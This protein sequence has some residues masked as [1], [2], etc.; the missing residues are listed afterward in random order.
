MPEI[1][2]VQIHVQAWQVY[3]ALTMCPRGQPQHA[4]T[5]NVMYCVCA[6]DSHSAQV[7]FGE[8]IKAAAKAGARMTG[9][10][11]PQTHVVVHQVVRCSRWEEQAAE[12]VAEALARA[13]YD[14]RSTYKKS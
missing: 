6:A 8:E 4:R 10:P 14:S 1:H 12:L 5:S 3:G 7:A 13:C 11:L 2:R 9:G